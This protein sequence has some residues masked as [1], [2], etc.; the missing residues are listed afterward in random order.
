MIRKKAK[1]KPKQKF[2]LIF[3][4]ALPKQKNKF[5]DLID[6]LSQLGVDRI[7]PMVTAR[8]IAQWN[9]SQKQRNYQRWI[10]I[11]QQAC[12][13][14][15]RNTLPIIEPVT[16]IDKIISNSSG[17]DLKIIPTVVEKRKN[18]KALFPNHKYKEILILIGPERDFTNHEIAQAEEAGFIPVT[19]GDLVLGVDTAAITVAAFV[20]LYK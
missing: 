11:S 13:Q 5:G 1:M 17:S 10:K 3:A 19:L 8:V 7:I 4:C 12:I 6:K 16:E 9:S 20:R 15:G 18:L 14:S 2:K